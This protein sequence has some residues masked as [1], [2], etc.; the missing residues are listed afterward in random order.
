MFGSKVICVWTFSYW[1]ILN[2]EFNF[3]SSKGIVRFS[4]S[5]CQFCCLF[6]KEI[7]PFHLNCQ[8][9]LHM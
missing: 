2:D 1:E 6:F 9:Y 4:Y 3:F 5:F 8:V 7:C